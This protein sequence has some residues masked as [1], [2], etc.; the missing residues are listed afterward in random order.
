MDDISRYAK[1]YTT[2][3]KHNHR[4]SDDITRCVQVELP[5]IVRV[6][7]AC[8]W[9]FYREREDVRRVGSRRICDRS[10]FS[11]IPKVNCVNFRND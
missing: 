10:I 8:A 2:S 9:V 7:T 4:M 5:A 11:E 1:R 3:S 6:G